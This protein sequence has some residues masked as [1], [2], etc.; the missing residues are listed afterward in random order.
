[1]ES[2]CSNPEG[3]KKGSLRASDLLV[4]D[5]TLLCTCSSYSPPFKTPSGPTLTLLPLILPSGP[6]MDIILLCSH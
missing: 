2:C 1:M 4:L 5:V 3:T 6:D